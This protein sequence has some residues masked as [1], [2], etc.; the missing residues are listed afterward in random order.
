MNKNA[1]ENERAVTQYNVFAFKCSHLPIIIRNHCL[2][3]VINFFT[4]K[5]EFS[6]FG[7][8]LTNVSEISEVAR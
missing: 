6:F 7:G 8:N 3:Y 4:S 1:V 5:P 2:D